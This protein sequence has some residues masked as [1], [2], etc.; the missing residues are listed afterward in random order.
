[1]GVS[2]LEKQPGNDLLLISPIKAASF[3]Y[4]AKQ[5]EV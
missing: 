5:I 3:T 1:M 4:F 2:N